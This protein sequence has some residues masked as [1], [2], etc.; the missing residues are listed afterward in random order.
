[1]TPLSLYVLTY[2]SEKYLDQV[3]SA[4]ARFADDLLIVDSGSTDATMDIARRHGAR[5]LSRPFDNFAAQRCFAQS[6]CLH[7]QVMFVDSDEIPSEALIEAMQELKAAGF[8]HDAYRVRR[9][10]VVLGRPVHACYPVGCPDYP[11]RIVSRDTMSFDMAGVHESPCGAE[12]TGQIEAA[13]VHQ[14]FETMQEIRRKLDFYTDLSA[15][16]LLRKRKPLLLMAIQQRTSAIGAFLKWYV[17]SHN[18][19][20]GWVGLVL[21]GYAAA[22]T[23]HKYRKARLRLKSPS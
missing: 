12:S 2:N 16:E 1:M 11:V 19:R 10:W 4:A 20:D 17:R 3:L 8:A 9:D 22:Y 14:T 13:L 18:W 5:I 21:G 6:Q 7:P 23:Y 15:I